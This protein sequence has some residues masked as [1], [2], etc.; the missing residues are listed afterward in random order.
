MYRLFNVKIDLQTSCR[1]VGSGLEL[2]RWQ[3]PANSPTQV[4]TKLD[5]TKIS[6]K[7]GLE[8]SDPD[9]HPLHHSVSSRQRLGGFH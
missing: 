6:K 9:K 7:E 5:V 3:F 8:G 4:S 1:A 2:E